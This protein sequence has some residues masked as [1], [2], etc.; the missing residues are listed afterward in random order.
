M[1]RSLSLYAP[2]LDLDLVVDM[3]NHSIGDLEP[4]LPLVT[5]TES[6]DMYSFQSVVLPSDEDLLEAMVKGFEQ[7]SVSVSSSLKNETKDYEQSSF[8]CQAR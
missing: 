6:L 8:L 7:S 5:P 2:S 3:V 1:R 4:D